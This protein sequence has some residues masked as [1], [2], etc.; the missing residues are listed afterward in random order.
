MVSDFVTPEMIEAAITAFAPTPET[1]PS[2]A[3][4][5]RKAGKGRSIKWADV[6]PCIAD[7]ITKEKPGSD[8]ATI[9]E[10][11]GCPFDPSDHAD[12]RAGSFTL[13]KDGG[14]APVAATIIARA[15]DSRNSS[16]HTRRTCFIC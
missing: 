14:I 11:R 6:Q 5:K 3:Y 10:I 4:S 7:R 15:R 13:F 16:R 9:I 12:D 8:G 1:A 2:R